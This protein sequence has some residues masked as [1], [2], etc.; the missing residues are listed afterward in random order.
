MLTELIQ[1]A[2][3]MA[4]KIIGITA[5]IIFGMTPVDSIGTW[6]PSLETILVGRPHSRPMITRGAR[7]GVRLYL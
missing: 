7:L 1:L 3:L 4:Q 2:E 5:P 6:A